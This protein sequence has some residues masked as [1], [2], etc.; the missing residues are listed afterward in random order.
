[1][2][3]FTRLAAATFNEPKRARFRV[4]TGERRR[5]KKDRA[6]ESARSIQSNALFVDK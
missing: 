4:R 2:I 3:I 1:V 5:R 6:E